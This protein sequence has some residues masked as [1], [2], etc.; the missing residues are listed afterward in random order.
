VANCWFPGA[1]QFPRRL[2]TAWCPW[3]PPRSGTRLARGTPL[4]APL[5]LFTRG[6]TVVSALPVRI[7]LDG[8]VVE[9][10]HFLA[11]PQVEQGRLRVRRVLLRQVRLCQLQTGPAE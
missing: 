4:V 11:F 10:A 5:G 6:I 8:E 3:F 1:S 2:A 7:L 9:V